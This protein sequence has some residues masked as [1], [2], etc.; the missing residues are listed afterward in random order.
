MKHI[1]LSCNKLSPAGTATLVGQVIDRMTNNPHFAEPAVPLAEMRAAL[2]RLNQ[3]IAA[4]TD[5]SRQDRMV[6]D[7]QVNALQAMLQKQGLYVMMV[8][9]GDGTVQQS[10]GFPASK[11]PGEAPMPGTPQNVKAAFTGK[12]GQIDVLW[13]TE[14]GAKFYRVQM[15]TDQRGGNNWT[16]VIST[17]RSFSFHGLQSAITYYFRIIAVGSA[18]TSEPSEVVFMVAA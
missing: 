1:N 2:D 9:D 4:A 12:K 5:G 11:V 10:S 18:G 13:K 17:R 8:S 15:T 6:R 16:E 7:E 3:L 14:A